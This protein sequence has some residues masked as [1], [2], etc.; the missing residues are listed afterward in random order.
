MSH[1]P[2]EDMVGLEVEVVEDND[3]VTRGRLISKSYNYIIVGER[4][5]DRVVITRKHIKSLRVIED[6]K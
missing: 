1:D 6:G 4:I 2:Y 5:L 3:D